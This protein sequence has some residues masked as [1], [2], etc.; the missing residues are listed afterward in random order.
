MQELLLRHFCFV[1]D[2]CSDCVIDVDNKTKRPIPVDFEKYIPFFL[3][4]NPDESCAKAGHAAYGQVCG[5][6]V[7]VIFR[8]YKPYHI[9]V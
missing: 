8:N 6:P 3:Q 2:A 5:V 1:L 7:L 9:V 4:D